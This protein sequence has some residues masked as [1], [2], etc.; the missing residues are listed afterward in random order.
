MISSTG[1]LCYRRPYHHPP[2]MVSD[3]VG[4]QFALGFPRREGAAF[5]LPHQPAVA[6]GVGREDGGQFV[7]GGLSPFC[8]HRLVGVQTG[9]R[10]RKTRVLLLWGSTL[11]NDILLMI[12]ICRMIS[13]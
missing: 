1:G 12:Y 5:I 13:L 9:L 6:D 10:F 4:R 2:A 8:L 7:F 3:P 11:E